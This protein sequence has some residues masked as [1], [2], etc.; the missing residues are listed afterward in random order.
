MSFPNVILVDEQDNEIGVMDKLEAHQKGLLHRAFSVFVFNKKNE[1][2]LQKRAVE[3]YHSGGLWT[4]S[5]CSHPAENETVLNA[6][7]RRL[8]EE[9]NYQCDL[10]EG[11]HFIYKV[12]LD[13]DLTEYELDHVLIGLSNDN[14]IIN[15]EEASDFKWISIPQ[16]LKEIE[17]RPSDF[18]FWFKVIMKDYLVE[19]ENNLNKINESL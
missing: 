15:P 4:N 11:F 14:P 13:N 1:M 6:G 10:H 8:K 5:C 7:H 16:V 9:M 17:D 18:T 12:A 2:L 19:L 3:K